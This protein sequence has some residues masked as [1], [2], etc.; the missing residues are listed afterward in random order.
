MTLYVIF[1]ACVVTT[2]NSSDT[3]IYIESSVNTTPYNLHIQTNY[4]LGFSGP[5]KSLKQK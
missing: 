2:V 5:L 1:C 3:A 4:L